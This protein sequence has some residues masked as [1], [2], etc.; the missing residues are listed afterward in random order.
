MC[1]V[2]WGFSQGMGWKTEAAHHSI[3]SAPSYQAP[4]GSVLHKRP[5]FQFEDQYELNRWYFQPRG[6]TQI[7]AFNAFPWGFPD[8]KTD[9]VEEDKHVIV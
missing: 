7:N 5:T 8:E 3:H 9:R 2:S 1:Q 6:T 4:G